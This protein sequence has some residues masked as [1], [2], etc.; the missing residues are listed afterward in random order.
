MWVET[1]YSFEM[2]VCICKKSKLIV[3]LAF[4]LAIWLCRLFFLSNFIPWNFGHS[5][6]SVLANA[7]FHNATISPFAN[8]I[9][10]MWLLSKI[11]FPKET[12]VAHLF[13]LSVPNTLIFL[14]SNINWFLFMTDNILKTCE[15]FDFWPLGCV[16][17]VANFG[18]NG[19]HVPKFLWHVIWEQNHVHSQFHSFIRQTVRRNDWMK[20]EIPK[21]PNPLLVWLFAKCTHSFQNYSMFL[22]SLPTDFTARKKLD[23]WPPDGA[24]SQ[25][26][27]PKMGQNATKT[28]WHKISVIKML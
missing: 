14:K 12:G 7:R 11:L 10:L 26:I 28:S 2:S 21:T 16:I 24:A 8:G 5:W 20:S 3:N 15:N 25:S 22:P 17:V 27:L 4:C 1:C 18:K 9:L 23:F 6:E 13:E 19:R